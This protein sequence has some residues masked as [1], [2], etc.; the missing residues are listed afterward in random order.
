V[1]RLNT[2][3]QANREWLLESIEYLVAP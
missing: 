2:D 1:R 3:V